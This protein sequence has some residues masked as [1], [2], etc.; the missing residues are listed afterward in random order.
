MDSLIT[1]K[2]TAK[3]RSRINEKLESLD[4]EEKQFNTQLSHH[5]FSIRQL[6]N[7][8]LDIYQIKH[9]IAMLQ[10]LD[11]DNANSFRETL[12]INIK[13]ILV[14]KTQLTLNVHFLPWPIDIIA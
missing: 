4:L 6:D 2:F 12:L 13:D 14:Y 10:N 5:D 1:G 7:Q 9:A 11:P 8:K 3:E